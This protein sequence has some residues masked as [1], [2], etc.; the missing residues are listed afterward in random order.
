MGIARLGGY[1]YQSPILGEYAFPDWIF[2]VDDDTWFNPYFLPQTLSKVDPSRPTAI[3]PTLLVD[4]PSSMDEPAVHYG[5]SGLA[6]NRLLLTAMNRP[7]YCND[8]ANLN[9]HCR[10][11][12]DGMSLIDFMVELL[13]RRIS[14]LVRCGGSSDGGA[15]LLI[16]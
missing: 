4:P 9:I 14:C 5:G 3:A 16:Y 15:V 6:I 7:I 11:L 10:R 8:P 12:Q 2:I 13:H 1:I